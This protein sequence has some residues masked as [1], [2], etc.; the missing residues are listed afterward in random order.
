MKS[1]KFPQLDERLATVKPPHGNTYL[2]ILNHPTLR[3]W[4]DSDYIPEEHRMLWIKGH[5]GA[6]KSTLMKFAF[7]AVHGSA[8]GSTLVA[9]FFF[10]ARGSDL[11]KSVLGMYQSL[12][13]QLLDRFNDLQAVFDNN[14]LLSRN[15]D[16]CS[17]VELQGLLR[18]S[19]LGLEGRSIIWFIDALDECEQ[20]EV[21]DMVLYFGE[22]VKS[23]LDKCVNLGICF[24]SRHYPAISI[25]RSRE[26]VLDGNPDHTKDLRTYIE[27]RLQVDDP[28]IVDKV[29]KRASG[30]FL[31]VVLVVEILNKE[32]LSAGFVVKK[33]LEEVPKT[34]RGLFREVLGHGTGDAIEKATTRLSMTWLLFSKELLT[35]FEY[36]NAVWA[37]LLS[38]K[39]VGDEDFPSGE[40]GLSAQDR[41]R[42][43]VVSSSK[44]LAQITKH[45]SV[46]LIHESIRDYLLKEQGLGEIWPEL[47]VN[48][49]G[50]SHATL[51]QSCIAY[52]RYWLNAA[53]RK[54]A[55]ELKKEDE[56]LGYAVD[57]VLDHAE[58]A[59]GACPQTEFILTFPL[60]DFLA[61]R[62][63][64]VASIYQEDADLLYVLSYEGHAKLIKLFL[65]LGDVGHRTAERAGRHKF[66]A[67]AAAANGH[68]EA[69]D[70]LLSSQAGIEVGADLFD[71][72]EPV[73]SKPAL[74]NVYND[75]TPL[76]W[77][78]AQGHMQM[79][80]KLIRYQQP[81]K[82]R[83]GGAWDPLARAASNGHEA[84]ARLLIENG[85]DINQGNPLQ[86]A[87][88]Y[89]HEA[90][91]R[92]LI[93]KGADVTKAIRL[94]WPYQKVTKQQPDFSSKR[95]LMST[96]A[97]RLN[98]PY[99]KVT[100]QQP[101]FSS[102][103]EQIATRQTI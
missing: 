88:Y 30:V 19:V 18:S 42:K 70:V 95:E 81:I 65:Q 4:Q 9:S 27:D 59:A 66:P 7:H 56:F 76:S 49:V 103:R 101:D 45:G 83:D 72:L 57:H 99:Q 37:G 16:I 80:L 82:E 22:L 93:E 92:L 60:S 32:S 67:L 5:P 3:Q 1:L 11:E 25:Q 47:A 33:R 102:E 35:P 89:G 96:K 100:K 94:N 54:S 98:W 85:A 50:L 51:Q 26:L 52:W 78:A 55:V 91:V 24:S 10:N 90:I 28:N 15:R 53:S 48:M 97:I 14:S 68:Q 75:Y 87:S 12:L 23:A 38:Q 46:Q 21:A 2:W 6:G 73:A 40:R 71:G 41:S 77:A 8:A 86:E 29:L 34:L 43:F 20:E 31:W 64:G 44:G 58:A 74:P 39:L 17:L 62:G 63:Y 84:I 36:R 61:R 13:W 69:L 79:V